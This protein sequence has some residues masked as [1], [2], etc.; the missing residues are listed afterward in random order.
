MDKEQEQKKFRISVGLIFNIA[1]FVLTIFLIMYFVFSEDGLIDLINSGLEVSLWWILAAVILHLL[2]ITID[3][4]IIYLF[5]REN[6]PDLKVR[7]ALKASMVGQF[8]CA[9]T[10]SATG[11]QPMQILTMSRSGVK[12]SVATSALIQK[13]LVWQFTLAAYCIVAVVARFSFFRGNLDMHMWILSAIGFVVQL[14]MLG[15]LLLASFAKNFTKK[16][17]GG[18]LK[19]LAKLHIL[20][21]LD[22]KLSK[23]EETLESFHESNKA[24]QKD[25]PLL[26]EV[27]GLTAIQ[28]TSL[29]LVPY[30][31]AMSF[32]IP[33]LNIFDM[34]CAQA[35]VNMVSSLV[36]LPGGS[37]AAEYCF[38]TFFMAYISAETMKSAILIWRTI[39]Y[40]GT[41]M[42][43]MPF[44]GVG[45]KKQLP[46]ETQSDENIKEENV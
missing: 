37:G 23:L 39:T 19:L 28:M 9:I 45:K 14:L 16:V 34:L 10:P 11:G 22:E 42:I 20:K 27:Y 41:I 26:I 7:T 12:G 3:A 5:V 38:S 2:N 21:N 18:F 31:I 29:F 32:H 13:F 43:S 44:S 33:D 40:Y 25:K 35:Y 46:V 36:P 17:A 8:Y 4:S 6:T 24:L 30:C 15:A 1:I